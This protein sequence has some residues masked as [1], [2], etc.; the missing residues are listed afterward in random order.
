[1]RDMVLALADKAAVRA[2]ATRRDLHKHPEL[3]FTEFRT[4]S[5]I[6]RRVTELGYDVKV[7]RDVVAEDRPGLPSEAELE[8]TYQRAVAEGGDPEFLPLL[9]GGFTGVVAELRTGRPGPTVGLRFDIDALP[10]YEYDA[11]EHVPLQKGFRSIH[12]G[13]MH[14]CGHDAHTSIGLGVA[15]VLAAVA[16]RLNGTIRIIFQPAE[17]G[18]RGAYAMVKAGV[19]EGIDYLL[20]AH[21]GRAP[22]GHF[23]ARRDGFM[24]STKMDVA[25]KGAPGHASASPEAGRNAL[26]AA[27]Q[28]IQGLYAI[29]RH[30][31]AAS[32]VNVGT[33]EGGS[34]RNVI[35]DSACMAIEV[36]G[37][38]NDVEAYMRRRAQKVL[39]GVAIAQEVDVDIKIV[40]QGLDMKTDEELAA[41]VLD[42]VRQIPG[43]VAHD[44][45]FRTGGSEDFTVLGV[46]VQEQGGQ[47]IFG[48]L[49]TN[50]AAPSHTARFDINE[51]DLRNGIA[52]FALA[53]IRLGNK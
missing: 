47:S 20:G 24:A 7:G 8:E 3:G 25:F 12:D 33:L 9:R 44:E 18:C 49:G 32:R 34:G 17:E 6:A 30:S 4:A 39:E 51:D 26:L 2:V 10:I 43:M 42:E 27:A 36:R 11:S 23:Y 37:K 19:A 52:L 41:L 21:I 28:A 31:A 15:E 48:Q 14:A 29:S 5:L 38:N 40:G 50:I 35:P 53:T 16:D 13:V 22:S 45:E 1:M 46:R